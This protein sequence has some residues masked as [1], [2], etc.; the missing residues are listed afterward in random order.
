VAAPVLTATAGATTIELSWTAG[1]GPPYEVIR[2]GVTLA[3]QT[4]TT[5]SDSAVVQNTSYSY[6]IEDKNEDGNYP[7][8]RTIWANT[9]TNTGTVTNTYSDSVSH[10]SGTSYS[11][12][13]SDNIV[14]CTDSLIEAKLTR[15]D[16]G[17]FLGSTAGQVYE[18]S[19]SYESDAGTQIVS[20]WRSKRMDFADLYPQFVDDFKTVDTIHLSYVD[21][22]EVTVTVSISNDGVSWISQTKTFGT[23]NK[24]I[25]EKHFHIICHGHYFY[26]QVEH[27]STTAKFQWTELKVE[28]RPS[29]KH[30]DLD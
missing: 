14:T 19:D 18:Y 5:Y 28:F 21:L 11:D 29:G 7:I 25:D 9:L 6:V 12:T 16:Y 2:N 30:F 27:S 23:G 22:G 1:G 17:Y 4:G 15:Q 8:T 13:F 3:T 20:F 10:V 24:E 26:V